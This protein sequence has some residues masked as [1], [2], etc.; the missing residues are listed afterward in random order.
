M[1]E[2]FMQLLHIKELTVSCNGVVPQ[3]M[4]SLLGSTAQS[5]RL[6]VSLYQVRAYNCDLHSVVPPRR[7]RLPE[8]AHYTPEMAKLDV[9][10]ELTAVTLGALI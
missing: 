6:L 10:P 8:Q 3:L 4:F 2:Y 5:T 9:I 7:I 1:L